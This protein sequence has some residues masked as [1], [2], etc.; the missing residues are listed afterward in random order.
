[1]IILREIIIEMRNYKKHEI[2][3]MRI[4]YQRLI[5]NKEKEGRS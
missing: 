2:S 5:K 1:M 4:S 3:G